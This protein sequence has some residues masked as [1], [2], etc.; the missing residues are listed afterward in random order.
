[1]TSTP[2]SVRAT[3]KASGLALAAASFLV[4]VPG[5]AVAEEGGT[6]HYVPGSIAS[7]MDGV[8]P[9]EALLLRLN[10]LNYDGSVGKTQ[11]LPIAG[12][13]AVGAEAK[14]TAVGLTVFWRPPV[15]IGEGWSYGMS[16]TV[17]YVW[18]DV[19]ADVTALGITA[20]RK[21]S[22]SGLGDAVLMPLMLNQNVN[23][24]FNINYR[25]AIYAPTG[26]YELGRLAN[27]GKNFWTLGPIVGFMYFGQKNGIEASTFVGADFNQTNPDTHY[28]S[29]TQFHVDGTF[30][31]HFPWQGGLVG[32][33]VNAYY[34]QQVTGDSGSGA[35]LG[36]F[37]GRTLGLGPVASFATKVGGHDLISEL[38]WLHETS[39]TNRLKGDL[40]WLK[41][42]YKFY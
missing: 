29:G 16:A 41:V 40:V 20:S 38:K 32:V 15:E 39:T 9:K 11:P 7:F 42:I 27:T 33:G 3:A 22:V 14:S 2:I 35:T 10:V 8:A 23:P 17:P 37:K 4:A 21:T 28:K 18:L 19:S 31:Q 13:T 25:V 24:D 30:A 12:L 1:M 34:Y 5:A 36:D 26:S 6:G